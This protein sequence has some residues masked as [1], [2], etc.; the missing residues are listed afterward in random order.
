LT[1][2][3]SQAPKDKG[4]S[5]D[6]FDG[7]TRHK[8]QQTTDQSLVPCLWPCLSSVSS[9]Q[10]MICSLQNTWARHMSIRLA[11]RGE[12]TRM[13]RFCSR[14]KTDKPPNAVPHGASSKGSSRVLCSVGR[15]RRSWLA[16]SI[17]T[18]ERPGSILLSSIHSS[19]Q[20]VECGKK[21]D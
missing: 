4:S 9:N 11:T 21:L 5:T 17:D 14:N 13:S 7:Q 16:E 1:A 2:V 8:V 6:G 18:D 10:E 20:N 19:T 3:S 15:R 12:A